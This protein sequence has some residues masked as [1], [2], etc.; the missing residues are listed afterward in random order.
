MV[1]Q[2]KDP[3]SLVMAAS[4]VNFVANFLKN[5][6]SPV[7]FIVAGYIGLRALEIALRPQDSFRTRTAQAM[8][9]VSAMSLL[10]L[11][12]L[13]LVAEILGAAGVLVLPWSASSLARF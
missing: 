1:N 7:V 12:A 9:T 6:P 3:G 5:M 10:L 4:F 13:F 2:P 11:T 8:M